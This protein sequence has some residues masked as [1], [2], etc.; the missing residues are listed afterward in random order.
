[1]NDVM[2]IDLPWLP[3]PVDGNKKGFP[4]GE[5]VVLQQHYFDSSL[6]NK[7]SELCSRAEQ[8]LLKHPRRITAGNVLA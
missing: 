1:M 3:L 6:Q 5:V 2:E 7:G 8:Q 4:I